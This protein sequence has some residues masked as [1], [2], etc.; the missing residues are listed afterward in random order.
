M[1]TH[2]NFLLVIAFFMTAIASTAQERKHKTPEWLSDKGSWMVESNVHT[3]RHH[4]IH[5][6]NKDGIEVYKEEIN[7]VRLNLKRSKTK[8]HLKQVLES[9]VLVWEEERIRRENEALVAKRLRG[10]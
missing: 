8:M 7:G 5:F 10:K 4:I 2:R 1:K 6:Y 9:S 3:P